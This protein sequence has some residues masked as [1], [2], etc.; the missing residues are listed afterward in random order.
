MRLVKTLPRCERLAL[1]EH[2]HALGHGMRLFAAEASS[3][4]RI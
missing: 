4:G 2:A 3:G 1:G